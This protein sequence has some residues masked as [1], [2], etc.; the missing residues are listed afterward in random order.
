M[1]RALL[2]IVMMLLTGTGVVATA[3]APPSAD[4][5]QFFSAGIVQNGT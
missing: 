1:R 4:N 5:V 3:A 2:A